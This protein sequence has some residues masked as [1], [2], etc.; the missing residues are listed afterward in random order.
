MIEENINVEDGINPAESQQELEDNFMKL[1]TNE[2]SD[3]VKVDDY[4]VYVVFQRPAFRDKYKARAWSSKKLKEF[5]F[6]NADDEDPEFAYFIR[7][8]ATVNSHVVKLFVADENGSVSIEGRPCSEYEYDPKN[9]LDYS[10]VFEKYVIEEL[11]NKNQ[12]EDVFIASAVLMYT[13]WV[14]T[15]QFD[16]DDIKNS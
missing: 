1:L 8:W 12:Q 14:N 6:D 4:D 7:S 5:G 13:R 16:G 2:E 3:P 9:D 11:Y 10:S 15:F